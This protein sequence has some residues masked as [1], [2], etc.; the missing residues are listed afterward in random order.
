MPDSAPNRLRG[1]LTPPIP[2]TPG[3]VDAPRDR[4]SVHIELWIA[5]AVTFGL[6][7]VVSALDLANALLAAT[8]LNKQQVPIN[9]PHSVLS[10]LDLLFQLANVAQLLAWGTLGLYLLWR[11]GIR[12]ALV[13]LDRDRLRSDLLGGVGLAALIGAAGL[14]FYL[15]ARALGFNASVAPSTLTDTWWRIPEL[16]LA[17][18]ANAWAEETVVVGYLISRLRQL[19]WRENRSLLASAVLRGSYHLYQGFGQFVGNLVMGLVFGRVWQ[20]TNRLWALITA[21]AILDIAS[22]LGYALLAR[23]LSWL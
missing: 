21:H 10:V 20:R 22:F 23:H 18:V 3:T 1:W 5:L 14:P 8:P 16:V 4:R 11:A 19:G 9:A 15:G 7:G 2:L 6:A 12:P 13:G 17:A